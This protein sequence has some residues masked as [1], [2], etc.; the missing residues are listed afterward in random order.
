[1]S[2][3]GA[4]RPVPAALARVE[5][6][7][8]RAP[9]FVSD[10]HLC[11]ARAATL[12]RFCMLLEELGGAAAELIV[13]GDLFEYWAG[14][15]TLQPNADGAAD[16]AVGRQVAHA[17]ARTAARGTAVYLLHGNRDLLLGEEFLQAAGAQLLADTAIALLGDGQ[18]AQPTLLAHGDAYCT[19][20][21]P[22][23]AFRRQAR[24]RAFQAAFLARPLAERRA[25]LGQ[26]RAQSQ[27]FKQQQ[28]ME[29][30]DVTPEAIDAAL[31]A[32]GV[33]HMIHGH[34][35]RPARHEFT[36][37]GTGAT[38]WVLPDW[39]LEASPTRGGGLRWVQD[40]LHE[41]AL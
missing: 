6:V 19:R 30:M 26:A 2:A 33:R 10:L 12:Q 22:Y 34:T 5:Q 21:L 32:A 13:L 27:A 7:H 28:S 36:L 15:D 20:D 9:V 16:D 40:A 11:A 24:D 18:R 29:I 38:R 8:L 35:H 41:F 25:L 37:D 1:M 17:L 4:S 14:D 31:R 23:Q 3:S 39:E